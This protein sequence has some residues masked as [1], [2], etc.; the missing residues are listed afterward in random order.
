MLAERGLAGAVQAL[1][2][3]VSVPVEVGVDLPGRPG[4]PVESAAYFAV[5]EALPTFQA[6]RRHPSRIRLWHADGRLR[7]LVR[8]DGHGGADPAPAPA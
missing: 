6:Q 1:A 8:D 4:P 3:T 5:A 2:L 7:I